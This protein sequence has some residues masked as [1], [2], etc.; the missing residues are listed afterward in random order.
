M[1]QKLSQFPE[2]GLQNI[3]IL[4]LTETVDEYI[5][6]GIFQFEISKH[7]SQ[8]NKSHFLLTLQEYYFSPS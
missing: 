6:L 1:K 2:E 3:L 5:Y 7:I 8:T 4:L